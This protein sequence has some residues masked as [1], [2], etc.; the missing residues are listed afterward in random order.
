MMS[1]LWPHIAV[2]ISVSIFCRDY[3][4]PEDQHITFAFAVSGRYQQVA[5]TKEQRKRDHIS[6]KLREEC[7]RCYQNAPSFSFGCNNIQAPMLLIFHSLL[8]GEVTQLYLR[9]HSHFLYV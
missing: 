3:N 5:G 1:S 9:N 8:S 4:P 7:Q 2:V 6:G